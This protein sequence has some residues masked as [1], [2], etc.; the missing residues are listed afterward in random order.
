MK[1]AVAAHSVGLPIPDITDSPE[2]VALLLGGGSVIW[3]L[4]RALKRCHCRQE[5]MK[6][7]EELRVEVRRYLQ[8][9]LR[10]EGMP[11]VENV[12]CLLEYL[13]WLLSHPHGTAELPWNNSLPL[14]R[15]RWSG[16]TWM[17]HAYFTNLS[18]DVVD[19]EEW[20]DFGRFLAAYDPTHPRVGREFLRKARY[21]H[22]YLRVYHNTPGRP[23]VDVNWS[24]MGMRGI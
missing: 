1:K 2:E 8:E 18:L 20:C 21:F 23:I 12:A 11:W 6:D 19:E 9:V 24:H 13:C 3:D 10:G 15:S 16:L 14:I 5:L 22:A 7:A 4:E 17:V